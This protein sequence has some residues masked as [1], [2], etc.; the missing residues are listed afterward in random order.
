MDRDADFSWMLRALKALADESRLRILGLLASRECSV[1]ELATL[2][3][4]KAPTVSHHLARLRDAGLVGMRSEGNTHH[5]RF[6]ERGLAGLRKSFGD[7]GRVAG[8]ADGIERGG[9]EQKVLRSF[10]EGEALSRIPASHKKR[11]V[12]LRW[13]VEFFD[14]GVVYNEREINE[15][16]K[17]HHWDC[18]TLRREF[19]AFKLMARE[20][21][22]YWRLPLAD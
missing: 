13:L 8:L 3:D 15:E 18:A 7:A 9:F 11:E 1:E 12:I 5:Y 14:P 20:A 17:R 19:I 21:G 16:I 10:V 2:V 4:L 6:D 22:M